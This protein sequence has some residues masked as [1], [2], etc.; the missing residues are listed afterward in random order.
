MKEPFWLKK[1]MLLAIHGGLLARFGDMPGIRDEGM[2]ESALNRPREVCHYSD[3]T[4]LAA[5]A[6]A[7][8]AGLAKNHPFLDGNKRIGFMADYTFI[9]VNGTQLTVQEEEA[10]LL[11][12]GLAAGEIEE[13]AYARWLEDG[14]NSSQPKQRGI[15]P[16]RK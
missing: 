9:G 15:P 10:V 5:L 7:Y 11:I 2:Q 14:S 1:E 6:A 8:T 3:D 4:T 12:R 13:A 16:G